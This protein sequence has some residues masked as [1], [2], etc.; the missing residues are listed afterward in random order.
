MTNRQELSGREKK[1][2]R[3]KIEYLLSPNHLSPSH[4]FNKEK[5]GLG[6]F[7]ILWSRIKYRNKERD[8]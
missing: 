5:T 7:V 6:R 2:E 4:L 1:H 8:L 3:F